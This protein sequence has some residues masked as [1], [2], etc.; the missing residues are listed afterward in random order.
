MLN[1]AVSRETARLL[2]VKRVATE[3]SYT[4]KQKIFPVCSGWHGVTV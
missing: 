3:I 4:N 2:N 1:I